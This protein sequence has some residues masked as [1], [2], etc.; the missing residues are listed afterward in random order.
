MPAWPTSVPFFRVNT[1]GELT[2]QGDNLRSEMD[3]G[4]AKVRPRSSFLS[5][6]RE[7]RTPPLTPFQ[8]DALVEFFIED[9]ANGALSFTV[10]DPFDGE[11]VNCRIIGSIRIRKVGTLFQV[12]ADLE[13]V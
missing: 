2:L 3:V 6:T 7:G 4:P 12:S 11:L 1:G 8:K 5:Q 9:L 10:T 13:R